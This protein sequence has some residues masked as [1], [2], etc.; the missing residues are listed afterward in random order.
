M[1][2]TFIRLLVASV[3]LARATCQ[4]STATATG[5]TTASRSVTPLP[6]TASFTPAPAFDTSLSTVFAAATFSTLLGSVPPT[7]DP[8]AVESDAWPALLA[9]F[10]ALARSAY[11]APNTPTV[12][13]TELIPTLSGNVVTFA[14]SFTLTFA[15][16]APAPARVT[17]LFSLYAVS[18]VLA[19]PLGTV[20]ARIS[21]SL[22][23]GIA[24]TRPAL[25]DVAAL[26]SPTSTPAPSVV[27]PSASASPAPSLGGAVVL[28]T[29]AGT[30]SA[31][32]EPAPSPLNVTKLA[33][34]AGPELLTL[35]SA[36]AAAAYPA[37][38]T[39]NVTLALV[40]PAANASSLGLAVSFVLRFASATPPAAQITSLLAVYSA[41]PALATPLAAVAAR[42]AVS[43]GG[44][45]AV[46]VTRPSLA[47]LSARA[48]NTPTPS[49]T[50]SP[51]NDAA[52]IALQSQVRRGGG[53][54]PLIP[55]L[56]GSSARRSR[57]C[58]PRLPCH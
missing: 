22:G 30:F 11:P 38:R 53:P 19:A 31:L 2:L 49:P 43:L 16:L 35:F 20:A 50:P 45:A 47:G 21:E 29:A 52:T 14:A 42:M 48:S 57:A 32:V 41:S 39:P 26:V 55:P 37:P 54:R 27:P 6:L 34:D 58:A 25:T 51:S 40:T 9:L 13:V 44:G 10:D 3:L 12:T 18:P 46:N 17:S 8:Y 33:V 7:L 4:T 1:G 24:V 15:G 23:G 28:V 56:D 36:L 5:T